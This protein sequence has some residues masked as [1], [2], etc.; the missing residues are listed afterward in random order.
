MALTCLSVGAAKRE[1][2]C[3]CHLSTFGIVGSEVPLCRFTRMRFGMLV[4]CNW[5]VEMMEDGESE[6]GGGGDV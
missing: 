6:A 3:I 1:R 4:E 2:G 5:G